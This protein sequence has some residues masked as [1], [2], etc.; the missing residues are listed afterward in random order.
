M[1]AFV[2]RELTAYLECGI[3]AHGCARV[4]CDACKQDELV[5]FSCK[6]RGFC[7]SYRRPLLLDRH[8]LSWLRC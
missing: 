3:L 2:E 8:D 5:A 4:H 7:P 6:R 1:P